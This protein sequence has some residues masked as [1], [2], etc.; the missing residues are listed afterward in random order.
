M[1][2]DWKSVTYPYQNPSLGFVETLVKG[3]KTG[4][5]H[6]VMVRENWIYR[7]RQFT[8]INR[9]DAFADIAARMALPLTM[10]EAELGILAAGA[11]PFMRQFYKG[12][13]G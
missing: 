8:R 12:Y 9:D 4:S 6:S 3:A 1:L 5:V 2:I 10:A 13:L 7:D 11:L